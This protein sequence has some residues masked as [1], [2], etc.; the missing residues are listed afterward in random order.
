MGLALACSKEVK[1][2]QKAV[3]GVEPQIAATVL[4]I[5]TNLQPQNKSFTHSIVIANGHARSGDEVDRWR[6]FD[7]D[8]KRVTFVD[9]ISKTF[10]VEDSGP[11]LSGQPRAAV[12]QPTGAKKV[13]Q[14]VEAS[15]YLTRLGGYQRELWIGSPAQIPPQL[16]GM[17]DASFAKLPGFPLVDHAELPYGNTRL[18]VDRSV[19]K[20]EQKNV[21]QSWI[22][23]PSDY[24]EVTAP[25]AS[26]PPASSRPPGQSTPTAGSRF[27]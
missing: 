18:L 5:Q 2:V 11:P 19:V 24:K 8:N 1:V 6:L 15:Q 3:T 4:T 9:D 25:A 21:P 26:R 22:S 12:L 23:V 13:I 20:I 27:F 14:G 7:V 10:Y 16:F 17:I